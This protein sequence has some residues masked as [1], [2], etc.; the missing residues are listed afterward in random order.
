MQ[1]QSAIIAFVVT[2]LAVVSIPARSQQANDEQ[3]VIRLEKDANTAFDRQ[4]YTRAAVFYQ[5]L[6]TMLPGDSPRIKQIE[7]RVRFCQKTVADQAQADLQ[8]QLANRGGDFPSSPHDR[9]PHVKPKE[10][11]VYEVAIKQLGNFEYDAEKGGN[12]PRDVTNLSGATIRTRGFMLPL[13]QADR[14]TEFALVPSLFGCCFGQPPQVQHTMVV[15][16]AKGKAVDY[17]TDELLIEGTLT[18]KERKEDGLVVSLFEIAC[19]S[20]K[21]APPPRPQ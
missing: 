16:T 13:D 12:I 11:E 2:L 4:S 7:E 1:K 19:T 18:V 9:K 21:P 8:A 20:V 5:Q 15:R 10:G 3:A 17:F 14:I 6:L